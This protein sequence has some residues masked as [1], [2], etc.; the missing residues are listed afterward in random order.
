MAMVVLLKNRQKAAAEMIHGDASETRVIVMPD[1]QQLFAD[2]QA[3]P[4][5]GA[6]KNYTRLRPPEAGVKAAFLF[7]AGDCLLQLRPCC[8][9]VLLLTKIQPEN[10]KNRRKKKPPCRTVTFLSC[11]RACAAAC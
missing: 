11:R 4:P 7:P 1:L 10:M 3:P 6:A 9:P 8:P 2:E 5:R